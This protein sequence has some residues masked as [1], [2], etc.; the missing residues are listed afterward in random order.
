MGAAIVAD[1]DVAAFVHVDVDN[2]AGMD[3]VDEVME[4]LE[5]V[6][7]DA[8]VLVEC[9][10][11]D[12]LID[13]T[14]GVQT[15]DETGGAGNIAEKSHYGQLVGGE[16]AS[17]PAEWQAEEGCTSAGLEDD[18][19]SEARGAGG[20][21]MV[22]RRGSEEIVLK[23]SAQRI[24]RASDGDGARRR[25]LTRCAHLFG[26]ASHMLIAR[27]AAGHYTDIGEAGKK[28][29]GDGVFAPAMF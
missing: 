5:E 28:R 3:G 21:E 19:V 10:A 7:W 15:V 4:L 29:T 6:V 14:G 20:V 16:Q 9:P 24:G 23:N 2:V 13:E 27:N 11:G 12:I 1:D 25:G 18:P 22:E 8:G 26:K 17:E